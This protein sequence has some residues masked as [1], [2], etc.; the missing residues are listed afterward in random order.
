MHSMENGDV[1][2]KKKVFGLAVCQDYSSR[3]PV[4][5]IWSIQILSQLKYDF[6]RIKH[7]IFVHTFEENCIQSRFSIDVPFMKWES[8]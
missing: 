3:A 8:C 4:Q 2:T 1:N 7:Q 6:Q 5:H